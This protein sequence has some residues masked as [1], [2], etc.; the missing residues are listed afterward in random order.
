MGVRVF[1]ALWPDATVRALLMREAVA[2]HRALGGKLTRDESVHMTLLFLG[3]VDESRLPALH[4]AAGRVAVTPFG[5]KMETAQCWR[6]NKVAWVGPHAVPHALGQLVRDLEAAM[7]D[8][9]FSFDRRPFAAHVTLL[10]KARCRPVELDPP[11]IEWPVDE[12]VLV[13]SQLG[14]AGSQYSVIGRWGQGHV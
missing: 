8:A 14:G 11:D 2:L 7:A 13:R 9:G 6:H 12:F 1:F 4:E 3:D 10:R 5:M